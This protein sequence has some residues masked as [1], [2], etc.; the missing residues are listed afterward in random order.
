MRRGGDRGRGTEPGSLR[1][2][3]TPDGRRA[4]D[5]AAPH[6]PLE[7]AW[8]QE[9][10]AAGAAPPVT[11]RGFDPVAT[12][13]PWL[14]R[15]EGAPAAHPWR[16]VGVAVV[17]GAVVLVAVLLSP[18]RFAYPASSSRV[19]LE[20]GI[21]LT[22]LLS[23]YILLGRFGPGWRTDRLY[24][25]AALVTLAA[26]NLLLAAAHIV[27]PGSLPREAVHTGA[28][29]GAAL[30]VLA[31]FAPN[32]GPRL[33]GGEAVGVLA[34][35]GVALAASYVF[36][37]LALSGVEPAPQ[38][39]ALDDGGAYLERPAEVLAL[40][41]V[42][43]ALFG[44]AAVGFALRSKRSG[45]ELLMWLAAG[46][47]LIAFARVA[48][49]LFPR[50][51]DWVH[52]G[53]VLRALFCLFVLFG[54]A[55]WVLGYWRGLAATAVAD[56]RRRI[57][58]EL[59]DGVAQELALIRRRAP[60][61][62]ARPEAAVAREITAAA[63]RAQDEARRA[64]DVLGRAGDESLD[65]ALAREA[66][67]V[68]A[69]TGVAVSLDVPRGVDVRPE[70]RDNLVRIAREAMANAARHGDAARI[71]V[72]LK[73][74]RPLHMRVVDDGAGFEPADR[75]PTGSFGLVSMHERAAEIGADLTLR[76]RPGTGTEVRVRLP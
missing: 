64:I 12:G 23:T 63:K 62:V 59:H 61:L 76:S 4:L 34:T 40:H 72:E 19:A 27:D 56:E 33:P 32:H 69:G 31:A 18:V 55:R 36:T 53:D 75:P 6:P 2:V 52:V 65:R 39:P 67:Q 1:A 28:L 13:G 68:A 26:T 16:I 73:P 20:T 15:A 37:R 46:A 8:G 49:L 30:L 74:G 43:A 71:R 38:M 66:R 48:Y 10:E 9:A 54:A 42:G 41:L 11:R 25:G 44:L 29:S 21:A 5:G 45:D 14:P 57:A 50:P 3:L 51:P 70:V 58:R 60:S 7:T 22:A 47:V 35:W 17:V 24:L